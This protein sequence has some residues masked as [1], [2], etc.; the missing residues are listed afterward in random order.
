MSAKKATGTANLFHE[1]PSEV[2]F[3]QA[4]APVR[5]ELPPDGMQKLLR[6]N[7][8]IQLAASGSVSITDLE[9]AVIDTRA[10]Q[11]LRGIRQLGTAYL[12]YPTALHTRFDHSL[13]TLQMVGEMT[14]SIKSNQH[15]EN[16]DQRTI[17]ADQEIVTRLYALLHDITH[18]PFG[19]TLEDELAILT[20]HD[21][22]P[23]RIEYFLGRES[24]IGK[25]LLENLP[26]GL[27]EKLLAVYRWDDKNPDRLPLDPDWVFVHDLVSN[28]VCADLLDYIRRDDLFCNLGV[29]LRYHFL[30]YLYLDREKGA[31]GQGDPR[32]KRVVVRLTKADATPRRDI[33][34]DLCRLME[35]RYMIAERV[36]F[37]HTKI[38]AG[39]MLGRAILEHFPELPSNAEQAEEWLRSV[40]DEVVLSTLQESPNPIAKRLAR[41]LA[42]REL[43]K[44]V[45]EPFTEA[46]AE[47]AQAAH[48]DVNIFAELRKRLEDP[49]SRRKVEDNLADIVGA[50]RGDVLV[51]APE[52]KMNQKV[53]AMRVFWRG[54][55]RTFSDVDDPVVQLRLEAV[56]HAHKKLWGINLIARADF[57]SDQKATLARYFT[58]QFFQPAATRS[59]S[60]DRILRE[61]IEGFMVRED[62]SQPT[63]AR[64][65]AAKV[66]EVLADLRG[67]SHGVENF[68]EQLRGS[69]RR[70]FGWDPRST[71]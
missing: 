58:A 22:N 68:S 7:K 41:A 16:N 38:I 46:H 67:Q 44:R 6:P 8:T 39:A 61:V 37:H 43:Y 10:F 48:R 11:R 42:K 56:L 9:R 29:G 30:N 15:S 53:A 35:A 23:E 27:Y 18:I 54:E 69:V 51:Y 34:S 17:T 70:V 21:L 59:A 12:V 2:E 14:R 63:N 47:A 45:W 60:I 26:E 55:Q 25:I 57:T 50:E 52:T 36:Y 28:T 31:D 1:T 5:V 3:G 24:E 64:E 62:V 20:R 49:L 65:R 19:H 13:G 4:A 66:D 33:L 32:R 40:S 71:P